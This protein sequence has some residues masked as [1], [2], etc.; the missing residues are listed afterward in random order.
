[1]S[2]LPDIAVRERPDDPAAQPYVRSYLFTRFAIGVLGIALPPGLVFLEPL[3]FNG[4]PFF[5]GSLSAYYYSG[6]RELFVGALWAIGVFLLVYKLPDFTWESLLSTLAGAAAVLVA[7]F[8][9]ARPGDGVD[10]TPLQLRLGESVVEG[11][12]FGAAAAFIA[13][14]APIT[15]LFG[16][17]EGRTDRPGRPPRPFWRAFHWT[18]AGFIL[19][20]AGL[21]A[22]AGITGGPDKGLLIAEWAAVWA[23]GTSWLARSV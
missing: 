11:I 1:M 9:T 18:C 17:E 16:R 6:M 4:Q 20:A 3:L 14:L 22:F 13:L 23:F 19:A 15:Y 21:A 5:R 10:L 2:V 12:H 7:L 8:P